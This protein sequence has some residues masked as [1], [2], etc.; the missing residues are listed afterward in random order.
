MN[1]NKNTNKIIA[2]E[3]LYDK[4]K[5][6]NKNKYLIGRFG[7]NNNGTIGDPSI[8]SKGMEKHNFICP[9]N[10]AI[11]KVEGLYDSS[12]VKGIKFHCQDIKTGKNVKAYNSN[13]KKVYGVSFGIDPTIDS[14]DYL[15]NKSECLT[16]ENKNGMIKPTFISN[17]DGN[18]NTQT[19]NIQNLKFNKCSYYNK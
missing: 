2:I 3:Y 5:T 8:R 10:S 15:Y 18:F 4:N 17:I 7:K 9:S 13:N 1:Y 14:L 16:T 6:H 12:G 11:Y 19:N